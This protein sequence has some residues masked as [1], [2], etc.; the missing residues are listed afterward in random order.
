MAGF[1]ASPDP[2]IA[3]A[4]A[5]TEPMVALLA[6]RSDADSL[7]AAAVLGGSRHNERSL[8]L[9]DQASRRAPERAELVWLHI[10]F[11]R[12]EG[13]CDAAP[14]EARLRGLDGKNG[15]AWFEALTRAGK[16]GD[17]QAKRAA[18]EAIARSERVDTYWT[19]LI[20]R[21]T[22]PVASVS[23]GLSYEPAYLVMGFLAAN[24][25]PAYGDLTKAC[26]GDAL[27]GADATELCRGIADSLRNGD[28]II[29][30]MLGTGIAERV[31]PEGSAKRQ[32]AAT[33]R[34]QW[35]SMGEFGKPLDDWMRS[36]PEEFLALCA[37]H[38]RERDVLEAARV[39]MGKSS[40]PSA[41]R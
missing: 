29:T 27:Q 24:A 1:A 6:Q 9:I 34:Q 4:E 33:A 12:M 10:Q 7:A 28:T 19:T 36:H 18:L 5:Q 37:Q 22:P 15:V 40:S 11:C 23:K 26:R 21:L 14:L 38:R 20:A 32:E 13:S 30:E 16:N 3:I 25:M 31:W 8:R 41:A 2:Q 17:E 39:A 35:N